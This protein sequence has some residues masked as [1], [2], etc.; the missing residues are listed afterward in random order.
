MQAYRGFIPLANSSKAPKVADSC[1]KVLFSVMEKHISDL[2]RVI[3]NPPHLLGLGW[4]VIPV[5]LF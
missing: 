4:G 2:A 1:I 3:K 5:S